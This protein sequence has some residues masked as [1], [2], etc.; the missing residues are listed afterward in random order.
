[1]AV[2]DGGERRRH[3][4]DISL[5]L[6]AAGRGSISY[7]RSDDQ[8]LRYAHWTGAAWQVETV[9]SGADSSDSS[10]ALDAE[11]DPHISYYDQAAGDLMYAQWTG[12]AGLADR[13]PCGDQ[14]GSSSR[15]TTR[16]RGR[17]HVHCPGRQRS[18]AH[19][20]PRLDGRRPEGR[21][22]DGR[23][24]GDRIGRPGAATSAVSAP[25]RWTG[26]GRA[27]VSYYRPDERRVEARRAAAG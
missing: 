3:V 27:S 21:A 15:W 10:L 23:R 19:H 12:A 22:V 20:L 1:M 2:G 16:R 17:L 18:S 6:D 7:S 11:G 5:A 9:V 26:K 4:R 8:T 25:W 13:V 14:P 24:L